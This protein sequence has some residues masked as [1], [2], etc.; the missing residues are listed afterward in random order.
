MRLFLNCE[1]GT[2][3]RRG[4]AESQACISS[5]DTGTAN[6]RM[7]VAPLDCRFTCIWH[8]A[9]GALGMSSVLNEHAAP[10]KT[11]K[12][13]L[14][15]TEV[16]LP[17]VIGTENEKAIDISHLRA[18]TGFI[19]LDEGYVNTGT[20]TSAITYLDGEKGVLRTAA[21]RSRRWPRSAA[22]LEVSYLLIYGELPNAEQLETSAIICGGT[23]CCTRT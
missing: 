14:G 4:L 22:F 19:T 23:P 18:E 10:A 21:T 17:V 12:L 11:G 20:T 2:A 7:I 3:P 15:D 8:L 13:Q 9:S 6:C 1:A 16:E 5:S